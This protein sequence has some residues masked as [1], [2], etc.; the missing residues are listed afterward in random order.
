MRYRLSAFGYHQKQARSVPTLCNKCNS[1]RIKQ[2][3]NIWQSQKI[4]GV[5]QNATISRLGDLFPPVSE[6]LQLVV[7]WGIIGRIERTDRAYVA[8][9]N[10]R[11]VLQL[12]LVRS[13]R[14]AQTT[15]HRGF[16][17]AVPIAISGIEPQRDA[18]GG[19]GAIAVAQRLNFSPGARDKIGR[20]M[21]T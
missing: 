14:T 18:H 10:V 7:Y 5:L 6:G 20:R 3:E 16:R 12:G 4:L 9:C 8:N 19:T 2:L 1:L 17:R 11:L 21:K 15:S 13:N